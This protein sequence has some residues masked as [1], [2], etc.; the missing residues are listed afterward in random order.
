MDLKELVFL[1]VLQVRLSSK[2]EVVN[3]FEGVVKELKAQELRGVLE[4]KEWAV[5][6]DVKDLQDTQGPGQ[7]KDS[8]EV[9]LFPLL[10][11]LAS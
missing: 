4:W 6:K 11:C 8:A 10:Q 2:H 5:P 3:G 1:H 9:S 7:L